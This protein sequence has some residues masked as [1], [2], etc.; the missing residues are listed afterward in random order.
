MYFLALQHAGA[1]HFPRVQD[2]AAQRH[3]GLRLAVPRLLRRA[4]GGVAFHQEQF[5]AGGVLAGAVRQLARQRRAGG[6]ALAYHLLGGLEAFLRCCN[7]QLSDAFAGIGV[8]VQPERERVFDDAAHEGGTFAR[9]KTLFGLASELR[10]G[11]FH[12]QHIAD[13]VPH[14]FRRQ[15]HAARQEV[16]E[17]A[18]IAHGIR[19]AGAQAVHV[20]AAF[21]GRNEVHIAFADARFRIRNPSHGPICHFRTAFDGTREGLFRQERTLRELVRQVAT[22]ATG[23]KPLFAFVGGF[24]EQLDAKARAQHRLGAQHVAQARY[25]HLVAVKVAAVRPEADAGARDAARRLADHLELLVQMAVAEADEKFFAAAL[26]AALEALG[27]RIHHRHT[28]TVEAAGKFV[29]LATELAARM[30][31]REDE[32]DAGQLFNGVQVHRHAAA[33]VGDFNGLVGMEDDLQRFGVASKGFV[34]GVVDDFVNQMVRTTG[35]RVHARPAAD[36]VQAR[37]NFNIGSVIAQ[38]GAAPAMGNARAASLL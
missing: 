25:Q 15:L 31:A 38:R 30:E 18:E 3:D 34:D 37:Q 7:G 22:K 1:F 12:A 14:V 9:R 36:R 32:F 24:V 16:P 35:V 33:V 19:E 13:A 29:I 5:A 21:S 23:V 8:L 28:H 10:V 2:L 4:T 17:L 20:G 27:Q 6:D 26:H 11:E